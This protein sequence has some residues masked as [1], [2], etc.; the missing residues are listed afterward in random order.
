[1]QILAGDIGGTKTTLAFAE[2]SALKGIEVLCRT[3]YASP[4]HASL[5]EIL[6]LF[7][8]QHAVRPDAAAF[9]V[10]GP[11]LDGRCATTNLPWTMETP[12][13]RDKLGTKKV[14]LINDLEANAWGIQ[15]LENKDFFTLNPGSPHASGNRCIISAGTGLG[16]AGMF[17][18]G[19]KHI[20]FATEGGH[21]AFSPT[22]DLEIELLQYLGKTHARVSWEQL[23]SGAGLVNIHGFLLHRNH[24]ETPPALRRQMEE[25]DPAA[26]LAKAA[27]QGQ[28]STCAQAMRLFTRL[29]G[30]EAGNLAL[31]MMATGGVYIG[32]GIAPK[33]LAELQTPA[34]LDGFFARG[35]ME[36]LLRDMPVKVILEPDTALLGAALY[37]KQ[38]G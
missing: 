1:M 27:A 25:G 36:S 35:P 16:E 26:A 9:G 37:A 34:F 28:C 6:D 23:V 13:L 10:A 30:V 38:R 20:P 3:T 31:K 24:E 18:D 29:Y 5:D 21:A 33:I 8:K 12:A 7:L 15:V 2:A 32:G 4:E 22:T 17:W 14:W 11:V 19:K